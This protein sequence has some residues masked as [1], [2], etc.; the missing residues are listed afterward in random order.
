ME[1]LKH[2]QGEGRAVVMVTHNHQMAAEC[3]DRIVTMKAGRVV[4]D[5]RTVA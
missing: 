4:S 5:T 1:I 3:A 2:L